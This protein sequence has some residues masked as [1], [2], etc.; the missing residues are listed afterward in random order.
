M[1]AEHESVA[2]PPATPASRACRRMKSR[3]PTRSRPG[4]RRRAR[5]DR[6]RPPVRPG[7]ARRESARRQLRRRGRAPCPAARSRERRASSTTALVLWFPA[8]R[9]VTGEDVA[10][11]HLHGSRAVLAAV[12]GGAA[13]PGTAPRRARR[14][15]PPRLSQ[16]QARSDPG[17]GGGR[18]RRRRDRGAAA[19]GIAPARRPSRRALSRLGRAAA[20]P[21]GASRSGDRFSRRGS[22]ARDRGARRRRDRRARRAR[23]RA[24][25]PTATA[26]SGCATASRWRSSGRPTPANRASSTSWRGARRRSPRPI[27]GT[28]RDVIEV[29]DRPRRL[30]GRARRHR[31]ACATAPMWSSRKGCAARWRAPNRPSCGFSCSMPRAPRMRAGAAQWPGPRHAPRRQQDR[32]RRRPRSRNGGASRRGA[33]SRLGADRRGHCPDLIATLC[34]PASPRATTSPRRS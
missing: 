33:T 15:H 34:R 14:I 3:L 26:A 31:R 1:P 19:P 5:G 22:A 7:S 8:P 20:A 9:S 30:S 17:R 27:A 12:D 23:S 29:G 2:G 13:R 11:L 24:I 6:D 4:D 32:S 21:P 10:E 28:T 16:R 18:S 25:S